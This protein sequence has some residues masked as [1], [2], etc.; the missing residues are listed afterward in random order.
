MALNE[1]TIEKLD[2]PADTERFDVNF[3]VDGMTLFSTT[4]PKGK[5]RIS[6]TSS[7]CFDVVS[8]GKAST[9]Y[10]AGHFTVLLEL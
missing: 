6:G 2:G 7:I 8:T 3:Q 5:Y 4:L 1:I 9:V 10:D